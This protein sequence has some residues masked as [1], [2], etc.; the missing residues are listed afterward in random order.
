MPEDEEIVVETITTE[1]ETEEETAV[2]G[3]LKRGALAH[4]LDEK[5]GGATSPVWFLIGKHVQDMSVEMNPNIETFTNILDEPNATDN[6]YAPTI[7]VDTYYADP[8]DGDFYEM[9]KDITMNRKT[10]DDCRTTLLEVIIDKTTGPYDA[11]TEDVII[12][13]QSYGGAPGGVRIPYQII[14]VGNRKLGTVTISNRVPTFT[15]TT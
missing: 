7:D 1:N 15:E 4:Y 11:W 13:P 14:F 6:G 2:M 12:K 5:F 3:K 10:D 8:S 9:I